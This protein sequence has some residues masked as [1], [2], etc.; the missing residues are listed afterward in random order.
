MASST[1]CALLFTVFAVPGGCLLVC[2][3]Q[4][5]RGMRRGYR[6]QRVRR[7]EYR[8]WIELRAVR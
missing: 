7:I 8:N 1:L 6:T 2:I 5:V 4:V 3:V